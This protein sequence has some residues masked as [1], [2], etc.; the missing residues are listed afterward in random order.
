M[1]ANFTISLIPSKA[2]VAFAGVDVLSF[3]AR[4]YMEECHRA[5][6][7]HCWKMLF[8]DGVPSCAVW[9]TART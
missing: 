2:P 9:P 5:V 6:W 7:N 8:V 4:T 3:N 1:V